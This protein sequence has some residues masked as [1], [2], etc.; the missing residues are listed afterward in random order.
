MK[1]SDK[2]MVRKITTTANIINSVKV[3]SLDTKQYRDTESQILVKI[4]LKSNQV[5]RPE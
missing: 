4:F 5:D 1:R 3:N 2:V